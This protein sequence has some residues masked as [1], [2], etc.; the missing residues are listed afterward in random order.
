MPA[1][2]FRCCGQYATP[3]MPPQETRRC[4]AYDANHR[5]VGR[6]DVRAAEC[7]CLD[8]I[9]WRGYYWSL[10]QMARCGKGLF[11]AAVMFGFDDPRPLSG[12]R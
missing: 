4:V 2:D 9:T 11:P 1:T 8:T 6:F 12:I 3:P 7:L 10:Q 5:E